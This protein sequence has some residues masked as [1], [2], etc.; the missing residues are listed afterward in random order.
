MLTSPVKLKVLA[1]FQKG[2]VTVHDYLFNYLWKNHG[3]QLDCRPIELLKPN[4][5]REYDLVLNVICA[6]GWHKKRLQKLDSWCKAA[7]KRLINGY[8]GLK[9][10]SRRKAYKIWSKHGV[11][12]ARVEPIVHKSKALAL[13]M[14]YPM[15]F[16]QEYSHLG[17]TMKLVKSRADIEATDPRAFKKT[18]IAIEFKDYKSEDGY[19]RKYRCMPYCEALYPNRG[20]H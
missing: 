18:T 5:V 6:D 15:I 19:Y 7:D 4:D 13:D 12:C 20:S 11:H 8:E 9:N 16:R 17:S 2:A 10:C 3:I 14:S 1:V